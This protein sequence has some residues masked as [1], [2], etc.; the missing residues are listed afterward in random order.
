MSLRL[1][2]VPSSAQR[3]D[4]QRVDEETVGGDG[5]HCCSGS[6]QGYSDVQIQPTAYSQYVHTFQSCFIQATFQVAIF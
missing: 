5:C 2:F 4:K 6:V 3:L 1:H